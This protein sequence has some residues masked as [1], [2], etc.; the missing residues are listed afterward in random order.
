MSW[1]CNYCKLFLPVCFFFLLSSQLAY[2]QGSEKEYFTEVLKQFEKKYHT[3]FSYNYTQLQRLRVSQPD[4]S[5]GLGEAL[6]SLKQELPFLDF[7]TSNAQ[8]ILVIPK[9]ARVYLSVLDRQDSSPVSGFYIRH[10]TETEKY[11]PYR[12]ESYV[13]N[14]AFPTDSVWLKAYGY[15][16]VKLTIRD[17][18]EQGNTVYLEAVNVLLDEVEIS[19]YFTS[20]IS[21]NLADQS[22][23]VDMKLLGLLPG[24]SE[25]DIFQLIRA[26]PGIRSPNGKPGSFNLRGNVFDQNLIY[27][28]N[29]PVYH[30]G[31]YFGTFSPYNPNMVEHITVYR[32]SLPTRWGGR[33][34]GLINISTQSEVTD[35]LS[36]GVFVNTVFAGTHLK[37]P[38]VKNKLSLALSARN[39][40]GILSPKLEEYSRL[41]FQGSR[42]DFNRLND[43]NQLDKDD[44]Q[45]NDINGKIVYALNQKQQ[46]SLSFLRVY[47][48][49]DHRL[50]DSGEDEIH[51]NIASL[52]NWGS[53][54]QWTG[55]FDD[56]LSLRSSLSL[57]DLKIKETRTDTFLSSNA[58]K[59]FDFVEN[60]IADIRFNVLGTYAFTALTKLTSGYEAQFHTLNFFSVFRNDRGKNR[61]RDDR[62]NAAIHSF[63]ASL[64]QLL[65]KRWIIQTG[66]R[67]DHY[68]INN[69][70]YADPRISVTYTLLPALYLKMSAGRSHQYIKQFLGLDFNNFRVANQFWRLADDDIPVLESDKAM[71]GAT[72][73]PGSW[74][75]DL[76]VYIQDISGISRQDREKPVQAGSQN[77]LGSDLLIRKKWKYFESWISYTLSQ[78]LMDFGELNRAYF[79]QTHVLSLNLSVPLKRFKIA[80]S[81]GYMSGLPIDQDQV[82]DLPY[83]DNFPSQHQLDISA[84]YSFL[85]PS[86]HW[87]GIIGISI[88]NVYDQEL[89][90]NQFA[91]APG[92]QNSL[93]RSLGFTPGLQL[94][95]AW[96]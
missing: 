51:R 40:L 26:L 75:F 47:N 31:H 52:N 64:K 76:E 87:K 9:R 21:A 22:I 43:D 58:E 4:T 81:W 1:F 65:D 80:T 19:S 83:S 62:T 2:S 78:T 50:L 82:T 69:Q 54:L 35:S 38:L 8:N 53:S 61:K 23:E 30:T 18:M 36:G 16:P 96:Q 57:S 39:D 20:G 74:L 41:N 71:L 73:S 56:Q 34:G 93:R 59:S 63:Y 67:M 88:I 45:F 84:T 72:F 55:N 94:S 60:E 95:I 89:I 66:L 46:L 48:S 15:Q 11:I 17:I 33:A 91:N 12:S 10:H 27:F 14:E 32:N 24:E 3:H 29:I 25:R 68:S 90:I 86:S 85:K 79:D 28:D 92:F 37:V 7:D 49:T 13:I 70:W 42:L 77:T 6:Q 5:L 44:V